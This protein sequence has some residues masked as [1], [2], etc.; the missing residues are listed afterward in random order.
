MISCWGFGQQTTPLFLTLSSSLSSSHV[1]LRVDLLS[2]Q[3]PVPQ[4]LSPPVCESHLFPDHEHSL[5]NLLLS[6]HSHSFS[7]GSHTNVG[8]SDNIWEFAPCPSSECDAG[9]FKSSLLQ[10]AVLDNSSSNT[11]IPQ[12]PVY[13]PNSVSIASHAHLTSDSLASYTYLNSEPAIV[14][15]TH[16][17]LPPLQFKFSEPNET[18]LTPVTVSEVS[19]AG[20]RGLFSYGVCLCIYFRLYHQVFFGF[21]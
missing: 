15:P 4:P 7:T 1:P 9:P 19:F 2:L 13:T 18:G 5:S 10:L 11:L 16:S 8:T 17:L 20:C 12:P 6:P 21:K 14:N 3:S